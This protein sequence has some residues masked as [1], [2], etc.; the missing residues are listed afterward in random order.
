MKEFLILLKDVEGTERTDDVMQKRIAEYKEWVDQI[1]SHYL[2]ANRLDQGG[3]HLKKRDD[4]IIDGPFVETKEIIVGYILIQAVDQV[5]AT[6]IA[7]SCPLLKF[8]EIY[9]RPIAQ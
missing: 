2:S 7:K 3:V 4:L 5:E 6:K 8:S 1:G 9:V